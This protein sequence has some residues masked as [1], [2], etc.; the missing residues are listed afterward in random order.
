MYGATSADFTITSGGRVIPGAVLTLWTARTGGTQIT[1]LLDVDSVACTTVT[2]AADGSVVYYGPDSDLSV[3]WADSGQGSRIAIR[4]VD[5]TG[6]PPT[7]TVG[8]VT[9]GTADVTISGTSPD[10]DIDFVLPPVGTNGVDTAAIQDSAVTSAKIADG[11]ITSTDVAA[12]TFAAHATVGNLLTA[13]QAVGTAAATYT[14]TNATQ[15]GAVYTATAAG[16]LSAQYADIPATPGDTY[17]AFAGLSTTGR[18]NAISLSFR[19]SGGA[20]LANLFS[21]SVAAGASGEVR[22]SGVAPAGTT[23]VRIYLLAGGATG[24][25][26]DTVTFTKVGLWKGASGQWSMPGVPVVG[27]SHIATNGAVHLSGTGVPESVITAAPGSTWLQ[28]DSTTDVKGWIRW[29]KATGTGSTGWVAGADADTGLRGTLGTT[30][31]PGVTFSGAQGSWTVAE[32]S[33]FTV[34]RVGRLVTLAFSFRNDSYTSGRSNIWQIPAGF[35]PREDYGAGGVFPAAISNASGTVG[36]GRIGVVSG[37]LT[38]E[39]SPSVTWG[40]GYAI[41]G[42]LSWYTK[43]AWPSSLPMNAL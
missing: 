24:S 11:T 17:T 2:S 40:P 33:K 7:L 30:T 20:Q 21:G 29:Q 35:A 23:T 22:V 36:A 38:I 37:Y 32:Y 18:A 25:I 9:T 27:G 15:A 10:Y 39:H 41:I 34:A 26:G 12:S 19:D 6:E 42:A 1:D 13:T 4:P 5:I 43:D 16:A 14:P 3:H 8:T 28:T 31:A